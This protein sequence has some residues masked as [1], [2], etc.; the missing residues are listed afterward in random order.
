MNKTN[1]V[2]GNNMERS[3]LDKLSVALKANGDK[4]SVQYLCSAR[5]KVPTSK[6]K[7]HTKV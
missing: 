1:M 6:N 3:F 7:E 5:R 2:N 4:V